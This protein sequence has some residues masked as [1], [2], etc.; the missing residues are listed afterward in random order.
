MVNRSEAKGLNTAFNKAVTD[1]PGPAAA[2]ADD[3][4]ACGACCLPVIC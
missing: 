2:E 1:V 4:V 3:G